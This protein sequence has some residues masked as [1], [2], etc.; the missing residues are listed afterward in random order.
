MSFAPNA[1]PRCVDELQAPRPYAA[2][3]ALMAKPHPALRRSAD[4]RRGNP[5]PPRSL[6]FAADLG[7]PSPAAARLPF[8][9]PYQGRRA[10][11]RG[12]TRRRPVLLAL[13]MALSS[14]HL[15][16]HEVRPAFLQIVESAPERFN[17]LWKQPIVQ[18]RRLPIDPVLPDGCPPLAD[19]A[20]RIVG[21]ALLQQWE[22]ACPLNEGTIHIRGLARTLTDV[23]VEVRHL[24]GEGLNHILRSNSPSLDLSDS[25]PKVAAYLTL[26]VE[27]LL[28]GIDHV[29]FVI[30]LVCFIPGAWPLLKTITSFTLAH[31]V[32]LALSVLEVVQLPQGPVEAVIALSILF[33]A[34]ELALP[35][36]QRSAL[37]Q[38]R[39][40]I[41]AFTFGLLH[42]FGFAGALADIGLPKDQLA[43]SLLLFN[44]GI[45]AGQILVVAAALALL[46]AASRLPTI[47]PA[48]G[49]PFQ[50]IA[51]FGA[52]GVGG[53]WRTPPGLLYAGLIYAMGAMAAYWTIDRI[54][55]LP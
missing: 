26:G 41:M 47:A 9:T 18:D 45:E 31:S 7:P 40:W 43:L 44:L 22:V 34:R 54:L 15:A 55:G 27:H 4:R 51:A 29:L 8:L 19:P 17:V 3:K 23:L 11:P 2:A 30:G 1:R 37:T 42:G 39:P 52:A 38:G 32:T 28:F 10:S 46:W 24:N 53:L 25:S 16:A 33:L 48:A 14:P 12:R 21:G 13:L 20:P 5:P 36:A 49:T 35:A 50:M 6:R